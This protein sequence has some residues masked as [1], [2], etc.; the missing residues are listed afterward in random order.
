MIPT[1]ALLIAAD[2]MNVP[3]EGLTVHEWGTFTSIA[4]DN[5]APVVWN[6]L[7]GKD[8]LPSF[9]NSGGYRCFKFSLAGTVRMETPVLYFYSAHETDAR[10]KVQFPK[11]VISEWYPKGDVGLYESKA[12]LDR[13]QVSYSDQAVVPTQSLLRSPPERLDAQLVKLGSNLNGFDSSLRNLVSS[14]SWSGIKVQPGSKADLPVT[15]AKS[16]Y[17][18]ARD[19]DAAPLTVGSQQEKFLFYRGVGHFPVPLS[20]QLLPDG[21]VHI[22][23]NSGHAVPAVIL[24]ENRAGRLG[25]RMTE[26]VATAMTLDRPSPDASLSQITGKLEQVLTAQGLF[27]KEAH[28]MV[29]T[30]RDSWFEEG[31]RLVYIVP[32]PLVDAG[33]PL[34][35]DPAPV[36]TARVFIGRIEL[37]TPEMKSTV[38]HAIAKNDTSVSNRY[39]RFLDSILQRV[40]KENLLEASKVEPFLEEVRKSL[41]A[42]ACR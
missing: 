5:G 4:G 16:H 30:W 26:G 14:I 10:V 37:I 8:D 24:F 9:V 2:L 27:P 32:P 31:L 34:Q 17:Y 29:E 22:E 39:G 23:N 36:K 18:S 13:M 41:P 12:M 11:G 19:T 40:A 7:G 15:T 42:T 25:F 38:A 3:S 35:V 21:Q 20:A 1:A 28:A 6:A 33:L